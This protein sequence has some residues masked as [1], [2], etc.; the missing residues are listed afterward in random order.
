MNVGNYSNFFGKY[1]P[2]HVDYYVAPDYS[3]NKIFHNS[4]LTMDVFE[5]NDVFIHNKMFNEVKVANQYQYNALTL[6]RTQ[7][8]DT[9]INPI[10]RKKFNNWKFPLPRHYKTLQRFTNHWI[11]MKFKFDYPD[12]NYRMKLHE[13]INYYT[14]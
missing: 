13:L 14:V 6:I 11:R 12:N 1:C 2:T 7:G 4:H 10:L 9:L 5:P 3:N 8:T